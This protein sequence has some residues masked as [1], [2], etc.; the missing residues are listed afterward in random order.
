MYVCICEYVSVCVRDTHA[1]ILTYTHVN[2]CTC[3]C[4]LFLY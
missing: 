2:T 4:T 3:K 1:H